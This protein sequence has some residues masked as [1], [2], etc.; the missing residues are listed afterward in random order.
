MIMKKALEIPKQ[1]TT[2][3]LI[4]VLFAFQSYHA[5]QS[6]RCKLMMQLDNP[7]QKLRGLLA[8]GK[9]LTMPCCYDGLTAKMVE[10]AGFPLTFMTGYGVSAVH[11][12]PDTQLISYGEM[13]DTARKICAVLDNIPCIGDGDTGYGNA[14]NMERTVKGYAQAGLAGIMIED[15]VSPKRCGHTKGKAVVGRDE[16]FRRVRAACNAR[17]RGRDIVIMARTDARGTDSFEEAI[18]RCQK[19]REIGAD[20]TFLEAPQSIEEMKEYCRQVEGPKLA[21]M[22][23]YG[24]TPIL[25]PK[26]LEAMGYSIAAYPLTLLSAG[27]KAQQEALRRLAAE[28]PVDE[29]I[30]DFAECRRVVGFDDYYE[31]EEKYKG[32]FED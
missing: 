22:L 28:E 11:G 17:D 14:I 15:Q 3:L 6:S 32:N 30:V 26:E 21:N 18:Y 8:N 20:I 9:I 16:A 31:L 24:Q 29:L 7:A 13:V 12:F 25:P 27:I 19:F 1:R 10:S 5:F 2:L 4:A 23:E